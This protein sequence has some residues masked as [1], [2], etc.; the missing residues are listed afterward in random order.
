MGRGD[1]L[2]TA[3]IRGAARTGKGLTGAKRALQNGLNRTIRNL[4]A[5]AEQVYGHPAPV[6]T[7]GGG[8]AD[9]RDSGQALDSVHAYVSFR[10]HGVRA[11]VTIRAER[12]GFNYLDSMRFGQATDPILARAGNDGHRGFMS[13][14]LAGRDHPPTRLRTV[15][16]FRPMVDFVEESHLRF[17]PDVDQAEQ[18]ILRTIDTLFVATR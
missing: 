5:R 3:R 10:A 2:V 17:A 11:Q 13:A 12:G 14:H 18:H 4:G 6:P 1:V 8:S 9:L 7:L 16:A 15:R